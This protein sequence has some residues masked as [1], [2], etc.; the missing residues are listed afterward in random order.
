[1]PDPGRMLLKCVGRMV[2]VIHE[3]DSGDNFT[4]KSSVDCFRHHCRVWD[5]YLLYKN[6][7]NCHL[8]EWLIQYITSGCASLLML[9]FSANVR[10]HL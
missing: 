2:S 9:G 1:M 10:N 7:R 5:V 3:S 4:A 8:Q 6:R